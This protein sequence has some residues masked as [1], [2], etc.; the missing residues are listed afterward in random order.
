MQGVRMSVDHKSTL[1]EWQSRFW[2][3]QGRLLSSISALLSV[4]WQVQACSS[5]ATTAACPS[6]LIL[7]A[8]GLGP[9]LDAAG[10]AS[11][12]GACNAWT[13]V[14]GHQMRAILAATAVAFA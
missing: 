1:Q 14:H 4:A 10:H 13:S 11:K 12:Q 7:V 5:A 2:R 3:I 9:E 8:P 6:E